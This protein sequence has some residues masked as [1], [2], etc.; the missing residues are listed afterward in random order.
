MLGTRSFPLTSPAPVSASC[1][2]NFFKM[3]ST[4]ALSGGGVSD[5]RIGKEGLSQRK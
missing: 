3:T 5:L 1:A 4:G 2:V